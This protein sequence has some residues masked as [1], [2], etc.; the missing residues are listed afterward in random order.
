MNWIRYANEQFNF[1][2]LIDAGSLDNFKIAMKF[3]NENQIDLIPSTTKR[4][5]GCPDN[6]I[7]AIPKILSNSN[8][9]IV[10][11]ISWAGASAGL[12]VLANKSPNSLLIYTPHTQP[13][14]TLN[15]YQ[16][17]FMIPRV[18]NDL[19][20]KS[21]LVVVL[22][23]VEI[24]SLEMHYRAPKNAIYAPNGTDTSKFFF[25][26]TKKKHQILTVCDFNE[27][28]KR[29]DL[30][31]ESFSIAIQTDPSLRLAMAG[32]RSDEIEI[33]SSIVNNVDQYG[34]VTLPELIFLYRSSKAFILLSDVEAFGM[35]VAESLCCG[36]QVILNDL[37]QFKSLF[38]RVP[39]V[40][41][42]DNRDSSLVAKT[43]VKVVDSQIDSK[44]LASTCVDLFGF[45]NTYGKKLKAINK[46][47]NK[48]AS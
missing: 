29:Y 17:F 9:D 20:V 1:S 24:S 12:D 19:L 8:W 44:K 34:Y 3:C 39:N 5:P 31:F 26:E 6:G 38:A 37:P 35:P 11:F 27:S 14:E 33:S 15:D 40:H 22:S 16:Q 36:T 42:V 41:F 2:V 45:D 4:R 30:L 21:D 43:M 25:E 13:L 10:E 46:L 32:N 47:L 7:S 23:P 18:T 48:E 28:R